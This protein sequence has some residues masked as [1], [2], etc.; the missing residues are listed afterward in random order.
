MVILS[1]LEVA[2][3]VTEGEQQLYV[4]NCGKPWLKTGEM[5]YWDISWWDFTA[6]IQTRYGCSGSDR[7]GV[8]FSPQNKDF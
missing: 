5:S 1:R 7:A 4:A 6:E 8:Q 2:S 3:N